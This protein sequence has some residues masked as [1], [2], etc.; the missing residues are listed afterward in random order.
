MRSTFSSISAPRLE[1]VLTRLDA[2]SLT[3]SAVFEARSSSARMSKRF[4]STF[5]SVRRNRH[6]RKGFGEGM[7]RLEPGCRAE[8]RVADRARVLDEIDRAGRELVDV[9][10]E[11]RAD[12]QMGERIRNRHALA[13]HLLERT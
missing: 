12:Q 2:A 7:A 8:A 1:A 4:P 10:V 13:T 6:R 9:E 5:M 3:P 11:Q